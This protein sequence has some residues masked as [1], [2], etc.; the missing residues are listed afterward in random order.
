MSS[1]TDQALGEF[2]DR[3]AAAEPTP[4]GGGAAAL[5][6]AL[7]AGLVAM[8]A[9]FSVRQLPEAAE[10]AARADQLR[11]R[12]TELMERDAVAYRLVIAA[13]RLPGEDNGIRSAQIRRALDGAAAVPLEI[14]E[15]AAEVASLAVPAGTRGNP[16]LRGDA[17]TAGCLAEAAARAAAGLV[18]INVVLGGL[19]AGLSERAAQ[20]VAAARSRVGELTGAGAGQR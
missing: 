4:G 5:T 19:D 1:V 8:A 7:A 2:L 20:A 13:Y 18:D 6:G 10:L 9:R 16:N 17:V 11:Q 14:A 12:S 3:L 15:V